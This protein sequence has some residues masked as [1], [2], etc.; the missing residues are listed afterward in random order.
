MSRS[1]V[2]TCARGRERVFGT[3][4]AWSI[5]P[6]V[7]VEALVEQHGPVGARR[8]V[9]QVAAELRTT[10]IPP[11]LVIDV[12]E[13]PNLA[14]ELASLTANRADA[15]RLVAEITTTITR[16]VAFMTGNAS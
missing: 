11:E 13:V 8:W 14:G 1:D 6:S 2:A 9:D 3:R 10:T 16:A 5:D 12:A 7:A 15:D 4:S